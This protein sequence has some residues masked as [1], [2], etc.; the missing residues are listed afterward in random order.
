MTPM[1]PGTLHNTGT[2]AVVVARK[3]IPSGGAV[4]VDDVETL[5][6]LPRTVLVKPDRTEV[7]APAVEA[8]TVEPDVE[9]DTADEPKPRR[10]RGAAA[11][12]A[13]PDPEPELGTEPIEEPTP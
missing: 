10:R 13:D 3:L 8:E 6:E 12:A 2:R 5:G 9:P 1:T 4:H 11:Q 7:E